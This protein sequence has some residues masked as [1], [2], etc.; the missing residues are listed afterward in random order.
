[1]NGPNTDLFVAV[2]AQIEKHPETWDQMSYK[3]L[4]GTAHC[5]AGWVCVLNE[6][7]FADGIRLEASKNTER[8]G[9]HYAPQVA[10][11][12]LGIEDS[13]WGHWLEDPGDL[14]NESNTLDDLYRISADL[15]G[16][17]EQVLRDKVA[18]EVAD[19][20][21]QPWPPPLW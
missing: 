19:G 12:L 18:A 16:L 4:C 6:E 3:N 8:F 14:F 5:F 10:I 17:D 1:M 13:A 9:T 7:R 15:L 2:L 20:Q 11:G 21:T